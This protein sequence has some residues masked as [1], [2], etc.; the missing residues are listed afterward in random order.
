MAVAPTMP[1]TERLVECS[2]R[3]AFVSLEWY[4]SFAVKLQCDNT[5]LMEAT[6]TEGEP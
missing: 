4:R 1:S 2:D 3:D 6:L 5:V